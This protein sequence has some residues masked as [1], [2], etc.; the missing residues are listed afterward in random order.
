MTVDLTNGVTAATGFLAA[1]VTAGLKATGKPDLALVVNQGPSFAA[2]GVFTSNRVFAAPVGWSRQAVKD[3]CLKAVVLNS[4]GANACT[5]EAGRQDAAQ[6]AAWVAELIGAD[7][8]DIGVCSTGLIGERLPMAKIEAG[9]RAAHAALAPD[10]G[11]AAATAIMTTDTKPKQACYRSPAGWTVGGMAKGAGMLAPALATMLVT[12]TTDALLDSTELDPALWAATSQSFDRAD[13]D[14]CMSTNDTVLLLASGASGVTPDPDEFADALTAVCVALARQLI[15]DAE[16]A[17][18]EVTV[19]VT[20]AATE[21]DALEVARAVARSNLFKCAIAGNDPNWGRVLAAVGT[22]AAAFD[23]DALDVAFNGVAV[24]RD[25]AP[26]EPRS[27][28]DLHP[29]QVDVAINLHAG[30]HEAAIWTNDLTHGYVS[31]NAD[32]SS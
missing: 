10:G 28:V 19:T 23:A 11:L 1:G 12:L 9:V 15:A 13:S 21:E 2:A 24:F 14:G 26:G 27:A 8:A 31:E 16:G 7:P 32:Y 5:G 18:H 30:H 17:E 25:G 4:G 6:T 3:G 29:R 20:G 22:T